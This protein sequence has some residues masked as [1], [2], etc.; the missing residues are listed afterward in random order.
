[1]ERKPSVSLGAARPS[2]RS[3]RALA[4]VGMT[5]AAALRDTDPH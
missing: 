4:S 3:S 2:C 5:R 1:M